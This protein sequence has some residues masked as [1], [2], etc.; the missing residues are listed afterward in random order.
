M[1]IDRKNII[2]KKSYIKDK[3]KSYIKDK[4]KS[5]IKD[6]TKSYPSK[7]YNDKFRQ[8]NALKLAEKVNCSCGGYYTYYSK[9]KHLQSKKHLMKNTIQLVLED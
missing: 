7:Q 2:K 9:S 5:Y 4:T 8:K 3:T 1:E 6:K